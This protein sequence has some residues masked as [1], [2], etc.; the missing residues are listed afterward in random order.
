MKL[1]SA[2]M[3]ALQ[4]HIACSRLNWTRAAKLFRVTQPRNSDLMRGTINSF[5]VDTLVNMPA[6]AGMRIEMRLRKAAQSTAVSN[7]CVSAHVT[8]AHDFWDN[9][10]GS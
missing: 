9:V 5:A 3:M 10:G 8:A 2:L 1:R 4:D 6:A 7:H